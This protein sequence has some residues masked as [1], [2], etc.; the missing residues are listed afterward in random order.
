[1]AQNT[2][3]PDDMPEVI[4]ALTAYITEDEKKLAPNTTYGGFGKILERN[5]KHHSSN[6]GGYM[7]EGTPARV[8]ITV[9]NA[10]YELTWNK[11]AKLIHPV[12][13]AKA[14]AGADEIM[15]LEETPIDRA[16]FT[17]KTINAVRRVFPNA[18][19]LG[20]LKNLISDDPKILDRLDNTEFRELRKV[21]ELSL[22]EIAENYTDDTET[23]STA[24]PENVEIPKGEIMSDTAKHAYTVHAQI[25]LGAQMVEDGLYQMAKGFKIMRD[26]KLYKELG[27]K[28]F[29]EYC[30]TETGISRHQV[31]SYIKIA[32]TLPEKFVMS[33]SQIGVEKLKLLTALSD[34]QRTEITENTDLENTTVRELRAKID[35]LTGKN[36]RLSEN[37]ESLKE[38]IEN[39]TTDN[40]RLEDEN[41]E[42][43]GENTDLEEERDGLK[44][45][46]AE[47]REKQSKAQQQFIAA[48]QENTRLKDQNDQLFSENKELRER[49]VE[50][51]T[52][53]GD[54]TESEEYKSLLTLYDN[55]GE[56]YDELEE[57][58]ERLREQRQNVPAGLDHDHL[59]EF[60]ETLY[61][62]ADD[63]FRDCCHFLKEDYPDETKEYVRERVAAL[64]KRFETYI[65]LN[66][67]ED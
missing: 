37:V 21:L 45:Q 46:L 44:K 62:K 26:E 9:G 56:Q 47:T 22:S 28:S 41:G 65:E 2:I 18:V 49:P 40:K 19:T 11:A 4:E 13:C 61:G 31:Y 36:K 64:Y 8:L 14:A 16:G 58:N 23:D 20:D 25:V 38:D 57:E 52:V 10:K 30:E 63:A 6:S 27:Y 29:E 24:V 59:R 55:L 48:T 43:T 50:T 5:H 67:E 39:L 53:E 12:L 15:T 17:F 32:D 7:V 3:N 60:F 33:T 34:E 1:M 51:V 66:F 35:E 42:L 54:P